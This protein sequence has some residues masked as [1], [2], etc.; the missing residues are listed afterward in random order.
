MMLIPSLSLRNARVLTS[1]DLKS[2]YWQVPLE[3]KSKEVT[4]FIVP[5]RGLFQ[6]TVM[7]F[8][9]KCSGATMQRLVDQVVGH[10]YDSNVFVYQDDIVIA[11]PDIDSHV[12]IL[13]VVLLALR[14][15]GLSIIFRIVNLVEK[16]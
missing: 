1:L 5:G 2:A 10:K 6:F 3:E 4:A 7:P 8:G 13:K 16:N 12:K 15:S 9:A 14:E 11:T